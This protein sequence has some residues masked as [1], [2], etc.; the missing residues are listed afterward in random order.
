M[1]EIAPLLTRIQDL[2]G[3][4]GGALSGTQLMAFLYNVKFNPC[5]TVFP[6]F[7][8]FL[9]WEIFLEYVKI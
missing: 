8:P 2:K 3:G 9:A 1:E 4:R 6:S 7:G 5:N